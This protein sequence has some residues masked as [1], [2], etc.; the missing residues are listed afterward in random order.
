MDQ[1][2][3]FLWLLLHA[4]IAQHGPHSHHH[5]YHEHSPLDDESIETSELRELSSHLAHQHSHG[6]GI[7]CGFLR[8]SAADEQ[9]DE[10][11]MANWKA[12]R[13]SNVFLRSTQT[14]YTIPVYVHIIQPN[15]FLGYTS[16]RNVDAALSYLN[17]AFANAKAPFSFQHKTT[18]RT[19][20][21]GWGE[22]CGSHATE[23]EI[24][25]KLKQGGADTLNIYI[26]YKIV[27]DDGRVLNGYAFA[28]FAGSD[29][30]VRDGVVV[31]GRG[32]QQWNTLVHEVGHFLGLY[33]T[34]AKSCDDADGDHVSDTPV[35]TNRY[36]P[37][38]SNCDVSKVI[39]WDSCPNSPGKDPFDNYMAYVV[40]NKCRSTFTRGQVER[41][42][43]QYELYRKKTLP[44]QV[45][46]RGYLQACKNDNDCCGTTR[47]TVFVLSDR[48]VCWF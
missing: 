29:S 15:F 17:N 47:C 13:S 28:P 42:T 24:K 38:I 40:N 22:N 48:R 19:I 6:H 2:W 39:P 8:P 25:R 21:R 36:A 10:K 26:C 1:L 4:A 41:M 37:F 33:H 16:D 18:T 34:F 9:Q 35:H 44:V 3:W 32:D 11:R 27:E 5:Q 31:S 23:M 43:G 45:Q 7:S 14:I 12:K 46:C 30:F 20:N